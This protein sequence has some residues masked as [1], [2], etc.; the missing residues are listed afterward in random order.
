MRRG[1]K[2]CHAAGQCLLDC[3]DGGFF[4]QFG[5]QVA[6]GSGAKPDNRKIHGY[7]LAR[8]ELP[9]FHKT[10]LGS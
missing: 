8:F 3:A 7:L 10:S 4:I 1:V 5:I 2:Q 9:D 6:D